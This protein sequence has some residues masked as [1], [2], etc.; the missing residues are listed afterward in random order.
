[1]AVILQ[2]LR[3]LGLA[4]EDMALLTS[5]P[6]AARIHVS[7]MGR[8]LAPDALLEKMTAGGWPRIVG[9]R[10]TGACSFP[11]HTHLSTE[12]P[13]QPQRTVALRVQSCLVLQRTEV[14]PCH[15]L[16][17]CGGA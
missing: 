12:R 6:A 4:D 5:D 1:M 14:H 11:L 17:D 9:F 16:D 2:T 15:L 3:M 13:F 8:E 7:F 10:P